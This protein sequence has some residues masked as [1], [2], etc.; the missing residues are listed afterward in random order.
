MAETDRSKQTSVIV[1]DNFNLELLVSSAN[2]YSLLKSQHPN[3]TPHECLAIWNGLSK[4]AKQQLILNSTFTGIRSKAIMSL[5]ASDPKQNKHVPKGNLQLFR[6]EELGKTISGPTHMN[7]DF[8]YE[9]LRHLHINFCVRHSSDRTLTQY[10]DDTS[11]QRGDHATTNN[12]RVKRF[13]LSSSHT[14]VGVKSS[15]AP[16]DQKHLFTQSSVIEVLLGSH[17]LHEN[18]DVTEFNRRGKGQVHLAVINPKALHKGSNC[19]AKSIAIYLFG[20]LDVGDAD[21]HLLNWNVENEHSALSSQ[22]PKK[23]RKDILVFFTLMKIVNL[24]FPYA[25]AA[26]DS[27]SDTHS[28][29]SPNIRSDALLI[30]FTLKFIAHNTYV[31]GNR[32]KTLIEIHSI[33]QHFVQPLIDT[34]ANVHNDSMDALHML[35]IRKED[36][37][38]FG[39]THVDIFDDWFGSFKA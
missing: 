7:S 32:L 10:N 5:Y 31:M 19:E 16:K 6:M 24:C 39:S 26:I 4:S 11:V 25:M 20:C 22:L 13:L 3:A 35:K 37:F 21:K 28:S 12:T 9:T 14:K 15:S 27:L 36:L 8:N 23:A 2:V 29:T 18:G 34:I 1:K 30:V 38:A 17:G 33:F